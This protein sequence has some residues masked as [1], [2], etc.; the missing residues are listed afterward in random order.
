MARSVQEAQNQLDI[1]V[2]A[3][4]R[5]GLSIPVSRRD[6]VQ[7][8]ANSCCVPTIAQE[9]Y[10]SAQVPLSEMVCDLVCRVARINSVDDKINARKA[11]KENGL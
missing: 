7:I 5:F 2:T 3:K 8:A 6:H 1:F 11:E 9:I 4:H 10:D